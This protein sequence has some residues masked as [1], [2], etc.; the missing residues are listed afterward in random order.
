MSQSGTTE[1]P[2]GHNDSEAELKEALEAIARERESLKNRLAETEA[3]IETLNQIGI[4]LS[5]ERDVEKLLEKILTECRR[6]T[7]SEAGSLYLLEDGPSGPRLRFKLAQNDAVRFAFTERTMP[8]DEQSLA[9]YVAFRGVPILLEDAYKIPEGTPYK[10][11]D[12]FDVATGWRTR[13]VVV[14]PMKDH[15]GEMVGVLQLMTRRGHEPGTSEAYPAA[16]IPLLLS[17]ATQA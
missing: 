5:A 6:F 16:L 15:R 10:H 2:A 7:R 1:F 11:N 3:R 13:A 17:L 9:G 12:L 8:V 4:A 14:V